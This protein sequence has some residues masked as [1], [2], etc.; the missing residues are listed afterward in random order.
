[1]AKQTINIGSSANDG[2]GTT[3]RAGGDLINDNFNEIY[4]YLGDGSSLNGTIFSVVDESSTS[5]AITV[6]E[7]LGI[8]GGTNLTTAVSGDN[9]NITLNSTVTGLTSVQTETLTNASGNLLVASATNI[10]EFRGDGSSVEGQIKL[11]CHANSHGQT[12]KPQPHS[13]GVTNTMLLPQGSNSTLVSEIATQTLTNKT[14]GVGQLTCNTRAYTGDG[15]TVA[16]TVTNG[17]TVQNVLVFINGVFQR[18]T[19]DFTISGT[20]LTFGTA[21]VTADTITIKE[22]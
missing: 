21:P 1:M 12:I 10:T 6:G 7:T 2:T 16:F 20:T 11:N 14:I 3:I 19:T 15:S 5:A 22:L 4:N 13:A 17:Q 9:V 8:T 18:P